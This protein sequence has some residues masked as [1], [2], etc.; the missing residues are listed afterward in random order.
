[1]KFVLKI[2]CEKDELEQNLRW[3]ADE[4]AYARMGKRDFEPLKNIDGNVIGVLWSQENHNR[5]HPGER[6]DGGL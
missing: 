2:D 3:F 6:S 1:M 5:I 4:V